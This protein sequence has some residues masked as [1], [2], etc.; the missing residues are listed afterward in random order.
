MKGGCIGRTYWGWLEIEYL[1]VAPELRRLGY[2]AKLLAAIE[3]EA[4]KRGCHSAYL[5]TFSFQAR[6][7]YEKQGYHVFGTLENFPPGHERYFLTKKLM[8]GADSEN[9]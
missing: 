5:D 1:A 3:A 2:G 9:Q 6:P 7:F 8:A 4:I